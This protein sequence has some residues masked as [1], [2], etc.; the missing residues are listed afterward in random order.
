[1]EELID[2]ES[3]EEFEED[4]DVGQREF[5]EDDESGS[6]VGDMEDWS[7]DGYDEFDSEEEGSDEEGGAEFPSDLEVS[8]EEGDEPAEEQPKAKPAP[9]APTTGTKRKA[10]GAP[11]SAKRRAPRV[12]VEYEMETEPLSKEMLKNW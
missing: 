5:V 12:D 3:E 6:E 11:K 4:E 9:K 10:T 2:D 8:D 1:M 7:A